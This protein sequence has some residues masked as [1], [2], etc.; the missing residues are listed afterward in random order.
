MERDSRKA[1]DI[2]LGLLRNYEEEQAERVQKIETK[3]DRY[4]DELGTYMVKLGG[5]NLSRNDSHTV[6]LLLHCIGDF[7][8]ISDH[9]MN[10]K[11]SAKE[12]QEK[13]MHFSSKA[14]KELEI[15]LDAVKEILDMSLMRSRRIIRMRRQRWSR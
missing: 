5:K 12:M 6:S 3:V 11:D 14:D 4:E 15:F 7:E 1:L 10:L 9:G 13:E 2:S 8:R